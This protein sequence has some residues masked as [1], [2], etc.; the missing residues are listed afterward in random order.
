M[1]SAGSQPA[2][3]PAPR[4]KRFRILAAAAAT[5]AGPSCAISLSTRSACPL[6]LCLPCTEPHSFGSRNLS[7]LALLGRP[8]P[9]SQAVCTAAGPA[10]PARPARARSAAFLPSPPDPSSAAPC[11]S[12]TRDISNFLDE[13]LFTQSRPGTSQPAL[14][15]PVTRGLCS[16][17]AA[18]TPRKRPS[19]SVCTTLPRSRCCPAHCPTASLRKPSTTLGCSHTG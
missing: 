3:R 7:F 15:P 5:A 6:V 2:D 4:G 11:I 12:A 9:P 17:P 18:S 1:S 10:L 13:Y 8:N 14:P 16:E 19:P